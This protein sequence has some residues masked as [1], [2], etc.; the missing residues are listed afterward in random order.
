MRITKADPSGSIP[1]RGNPS[2]RGALFASRCLERF[3]KIVTDLSVYKMQGILCDPEMVSGM[4]SFQDEIRLLLG[5]KMPVSGILFYG[6]STIRLWETFQRDFSPLPVGNLGF[7]GSSLKACDEAFLTLIP[8]HSPAALVLYAGDNDLDQGASPAE[9]VASFCSMIQK[10]RASCPVDIPVAMISIKPSPSR[11]GGGVRIRQANRALEEECHRHKNVWFLDVLPNFLDGDLRPK[12]RLFGQDLLH[13]SEEG[14]AILCAIVQRWLIQRGFDPAL[15]GE[16]WVEIPP[17]PL[18]PQTL[19]ISHAPLKWE[20]DPEI[21][22]EYHVWHSP[23]LNREMELLV[24]GHAGERMLVFPS[25]MERFYEWENRGM[26]HAC[27]S[28]IASGRLQLWCVDSLDAE[29]F[30]AFEKPPSERI[31]RHYLYERY[32]LEEVLPLSER[33]NPQSPLGVT[34]CSLGA[35]HA[36]AIALRHPNRFQ[37]LVALSGRFDLSHAYSSN[38]PDLFHG[39]RELPLYFL[40]PNQFL[41]NLN[42]SALLGRLREMEILLAVGEDDEFRHSNETLSHILWNRGV[43]HRLSLWVG[44]SHRFRAWRQMARLYI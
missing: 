17:S 4:E 26:I 9:I 16:N 29:S 28:A 30:F 42:D 22:R 18:L 37:R 38:Y 20:A 1:Q 15:R 14:Y 41:P 12:R 43:S 32:L 39:Y 6:S 21:K 40:M 8:R 7:G 5:S 3:P 13:L 34:G 36:A 11:W 24:F 35:F 31:A 23:I 10:I 33:C 19:R 2:G 25:R 44:Q 27:R